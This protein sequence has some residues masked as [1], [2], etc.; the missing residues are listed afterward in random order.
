MAEELALAGEVDDR[1]AGVDVRRDGVV[2]GDQGDRDRDERVEAEPVGDRRGHQGEQEEEPPLPPEPEPGQGVGGGDADQEA[3]R[4][5]R[6]HVRI[7]R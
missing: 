3:V 6:A 1:V 4:R 5:P 2:A 7:V